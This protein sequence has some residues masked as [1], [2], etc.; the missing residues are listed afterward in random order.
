ML[1]AIELR[2][3]GRTLDF[4]GRKVHAHPATVSK[5]IRNYEIYGDSLFTGYPTVM[6]QSSD[7]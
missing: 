2:E 7:D 4:I 3:R 1:K 5:W 6:V